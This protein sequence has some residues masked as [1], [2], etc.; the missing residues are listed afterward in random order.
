LVGSGGMGTVWKV[1][2]KELN[3]TFAIKVLNPDLVADETANK[4]FQKEAKL[5]SELTHANIAAIFGPGTDT[6][7]RPYIIMRYV[8]GESL[9]DILKR[10]SKLSEERAL[11]IFKQVCEA[12]SHSHMKGI[13]HRDIK[14]SNIIISKTESGGDLVQ[15]VDFGIARYIY[16]EV[17]KTQALTKAVDIFGSPNVHEPRTVSRRRN[18]RSIRHLLT[19]LRPLRDAHRHS[20][21]YR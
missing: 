13:V 17:T 1:F 16:E 11:D 14:P 12:L 10:E 21:F 19:R 7:G 9:A 4:R 8:D 15:I 18:H 5:A 20:T 2:D 6:H 3:E